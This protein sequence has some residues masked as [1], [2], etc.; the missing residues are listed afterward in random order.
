MHSGHFLS[1]ATNPSSVISKPIVSS[2]V[3]FS[4]FYISSSV[5]ASNS[6]V[7]KLPSSSNSHSLVD[8]LKLMCS[9][10]GEMAGGVSCAWPKQ[11]W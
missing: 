3:L 2:S 4:M 5:L 10:K 6:A 9:E 11:L 7:L 1:F 8:T